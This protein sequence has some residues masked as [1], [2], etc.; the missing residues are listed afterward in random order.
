MTRLDLLP[1]NALA[2]MLK[3][4]EDDIREIKNKQRHSG[5]S[6]LQGYLV[7]T[8]DE[9][10]LHETSAVNES[11]I[12]E[13]IYTGSGSQPFPIEQLYIDIFFGGTEEG[14]R[15]NPLNFTYDDGVN[16]VVVE[17]VP[18]FDTAYSGS[19]LQYRWTY[20]FFITGTLEWYFK[21]HVHG[22]SDGSVEVNK[23]AF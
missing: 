5:T 9:W 15:P 4:A 21:A 18:V 1:E 11:V 19:E 20:T 14:N 10:D 7:E 3:Q 2:T 12:I 13:V 22:S 23:V 8:A 6:G 17:P 16:F